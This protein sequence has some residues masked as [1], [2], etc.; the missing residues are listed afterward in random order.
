M[1][2]PTMLHD[3]I[4]HDFLEAVKAR[5]ADDHFIDDKE[6]CEILQ[7]ALRR[8]VS[9]E[10]ARRCLVEVCAENGYVIEREAIDEA[11]ALLQ[12]RA[13]TGGAIRESDFRDALAVLLER[14]N[15]QR[16]ERECSRI[17]VRIIEEYGLPIHHGWWR[18]WYAKVKRSLA[19]GRRNGR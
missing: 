9:M 3:A 4:K 1:N 10:T 5:A 13:R 19:M 16:S 15:G 8:G 14:M 17:L 12:A 7:I 11:K 18:N 2:G 6:E